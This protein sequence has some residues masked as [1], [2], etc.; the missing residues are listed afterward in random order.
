[1]KRILVVD[2]SAISREI[3][4]KVLGQAYDVVK[5]ASGEEALLRIGEIAPD[6]VIL[7]LLMPGM[8]GFEVLGRLKAA[9]ISIPVFVLSADIQKSTR[10]KILE[11]GAVGMIN[12]PVDPESLRS[13]VASLLGGHP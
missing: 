10:T 3:V 7:D 5:A 8:D 11:L 4:T 13:T 12:K 9:G 2:D 6:L 1:M